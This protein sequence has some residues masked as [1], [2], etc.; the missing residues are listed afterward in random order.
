MKRKITLIK[1]SHVIIIISSILIVFISFFCTTLFYNRYCEM[2]NC[3]V[4]IISKDYETK[5]YIKEVIYEDEQKI[6]I[7]D[8]Y[9]K[10]FT[11]DK[12]DYIIKYRYNK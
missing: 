12:Q 5:Y 9:G 4:Q 6:S 11:F 3:P 2:N 7:M 8:I 1:G 10:T